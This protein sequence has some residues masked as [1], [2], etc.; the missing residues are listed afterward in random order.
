MLHKYRDNRVRQTFLNNLSVDIKKEVLK[1]DAEHNEKKEDSGISPKVARSKFKDG[2]RKIST[3]MTRIPLLRKISSSS[4]YRPS[5][6]KDISGL[7]SLGSQPSES[8][9]RI[10]STHNE[11]FFVVTHNLDAPITFLRESGV[12]QNDKHIA[13]PVE[14]DESSH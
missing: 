13:R 7:Q 3:D 6:L 9:S 14:L 1:F 12:A 10:R 5:I 8:N 4:S 2:Q 11:D